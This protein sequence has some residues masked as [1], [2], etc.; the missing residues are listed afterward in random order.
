MRQFLLLITI[1]LHL[2]STS[3]KFGINIDS[4]KETEVEVDS[5]GNTN[6]IQQ[7][8]LELLEAIKKAH[9]SLEHQAAVDLTA[10]IEAASKD[11]E[12]SVM[13][14]RLKDSP[15]MKKLKKEAN[16]AQIVQ[17]MITALEEMKLLDYLFQDPNR[18]LVEMEKEGMIDKKHL[19][20]YKENPGLLEEDTRKSLWFNFVSLA[21]A[22]GYL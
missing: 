19:E 20:T 2:T 10:V 21:A 22:G 12:T 1:L 17:G 16:E 3:S 4:L 13:A 14:Q 8:S 11:T 18:A 15:E 9:P 7:V 6:E 5:N